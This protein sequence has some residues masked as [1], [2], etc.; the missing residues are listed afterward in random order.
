MASFDSVGFDF[1]L[2]LDIDRVSWSI[3]K[4]ATPTIACIALWA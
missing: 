1:F 2:R 3:R 4:A